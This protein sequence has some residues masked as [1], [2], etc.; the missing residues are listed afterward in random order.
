MTDATVPA[1]GA[2][3]PPTLLT[4]EQTDEGNALNTGGV[5]KA[6]RLSS[7]CLLHI[8]TTAVDRLLRE[9]KNRA[10]E[11]RAAMADNARKARV[12]HSTKPSSKSSPW[13]QRSPTSSPGSKKKSS[14]P[15]KKST[16][17][18]SP[19]RNGFPPPLWQ[20]APAYAED[21]FFNGAPVFSGEAGSSVEQDE[22]TSSP[23]GGQRARMLRRAVTGGAEEGHYA[24]THSCTK[25]A[26]PS[27]KRPKK[28]K[29]SDRRADERSPTSASPTPARR[30]E[31]AANLG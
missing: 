2:P 28:K 3:A 22:E 25:N 15:P 12:Q 8:T 20:P 4:E 10:A 14:P 23:Y 13:E 30:S 19:D 26:T 6:R 18:G 11:A 9:E 1:D 16:L 29:S 24:T 31:G 21:D 27:N 7:E 5:E 17:N